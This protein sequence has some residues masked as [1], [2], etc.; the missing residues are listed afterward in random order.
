MGWGIREGGR[1]AKDNLTYTEEG[2]CVRCGGDGN[3]SSIPGYLQC[4]RCEFEWKDPNDATESSGPRDSISRDTE[5]LEE[6]KKEMES[7]E[8]LARV[9]GVD[10]GLDAAQKESINRLQGKWMKGMHG[11]YN[12]AEEERKPLMISFDDD[13]NLL[14]TQVGAIHLS[15]NTFD[16]GEEI[17]IEYPGVG[18]EFFC[19]NEDSEQGWRRGRTLEETARNIASI[20]NRK[21][22]LAHASANEASVCIELRDARLDADSL[23]IYVAD[24]GEKNMVVERL[25]IILDPDEVQVY[26]DYHAAVRLTLADGIIT[27]SE[28][29]LLWAMRQN[30]GIS[31]Q[32][33]VRIVIDLFGAD[34]VKECPSCGINAPLYPEH[35]AWW[36]EGCQQWV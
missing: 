19:F 9:L 1:Q 7:G 25:G 35:N 8:G 24:P 16:G 34:A 4:A 10:D 14:E 23:V 18:T 32:D 21:S 13:D 3:P 2:D 11:H 12:A 22:R 27:P 28:D 36:C 26:E 30:L 6:F 5:R 31:E 29:Q 20:I 17:R 15:Q 33:H